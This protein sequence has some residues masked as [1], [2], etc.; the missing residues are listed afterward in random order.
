[1][2][3]IALAILLADPPEVLLLDEPTNHLS[4]G[5]VTAIEGALAGYPGTVVIASHDRWLRNRWAGLQL[6]LSTAPA[7]VNTEL[8]RP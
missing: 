2:K 6:T 4:L 5:L 8:S 7:S 1:M 3:R